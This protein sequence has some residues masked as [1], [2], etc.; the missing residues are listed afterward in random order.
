VRARHAL[1]AALVSCGEPALSG[2]DE[3]IVIDRARFKEGELPVD[4]ARVTPKVT[5]V[6]SV[7]NIL[8]RGQTGKV[9]AGRVTDDASA[10]GV[11][12]GDEGTGYW[13]APLGAA[14]PQ[15]PGEL[16]WSLSLDVAHDVKTGLQP[17]RFAALDGDGNGGPV[18]ELPVCVVPDVP[19]NLNACDPAIPPP[20]AVVSLEWDADVDLDL[21]VYTPEGKFVDP[22]HPSTA[23]PEEGEIDPA[24]ADGVFDHDGFAGCEANGARRENLVFQAKPSPGVYYVFV[25]LFDAC[26]ASSVRY[27]ASLHLPSGE[28]ATLGE[29]LHVEGELLADQEQ[30]GVGLGSFTTEFLIQ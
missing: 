6:D 20:G 9:V 30:G 1:F 17:L 12:L 29:V 5:I 15:A 2:L 16:T 18:F 13:L 11:V 21:V 14:D 8:R 28:P 7:N 4:P 23:L 26:D 27:R 19:D 10:I 22:K 25:T 24:D 3:P